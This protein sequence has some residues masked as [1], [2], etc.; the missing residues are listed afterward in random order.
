MLGA[1]R[2]NPGSGNACWREKRRRDVNGVNPL[3]FPAWGISLAHLGEG[4][5]HSSGLIACEPL[6]REQGG[7]G[8]DSPS[9]SSCPLKDE[10]AYIVKKSL[11]GVLPKL[12]V[13]HLLENPHPGRHEEGEG[14]RSDTWNRGTKPPSLQI[15]IHQLLRATSPT[16]THM[17][18]DVRELSPAS[19]PAGSAGIVAPTYLAATT[20]KPG[21]HPLRLS[22]SPMPGGGRHNTVT[23][24][25]QVPAAYSDLPLPHPWFVRHV[26]SK[27]IKHRLPKVSHSP[28]LLFWLNRGD[29]NHSF[30]LCFRDCARF[31]QKDVNV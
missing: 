30:P 3:H 9:G 21:V 7:R 26:P 1:R 31:R 5:L 17:A 27:P 11:F 14:E 19:I 4:T 28:E 12:L 6:C 15:N 29:S 22:W 18:K 10:V 20:R 23:V 13:Q 24:S 25:H 16:A 2:R 8:G